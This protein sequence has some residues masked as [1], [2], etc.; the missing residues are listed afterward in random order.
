MDLMLVVFFT[1][2][3]VV[4]FGAIIKPIKKMFLTEPLAA[5]VIGVVLG[6]EVLDIIHTSTVHKDKILEIAAEF[7][8]AM[9][10]MATAFRMPPRFFRKN[11]S[12]LSSIV[13]LGMIL[14]WLATA[15]ILY[16]LLDLSFAECLLIGAIVTPTD[17]VVATTIVTGEMAEKFL[18]SSVRDTISF[19][20]GVNDGL[21]YPIVF[22]SIFLV[23][24][25]DFPLGEW[26]FRTFL[27]QTVCSAVLGYGIGYLAGLMM[28]RAD[29]AGF[30][31]KKAVLPFSLALGFLLLSGLDSLKMNGIIGVFTG[32][33]AFAERLSK[34]EDIMEERVQES[35]ERIFIIPIF[36]L[37]G[38]FLPWKEWH[39]LGWTAVWIVLLVI[40]FRRIPA[41]LAL[42]PLMKKF[43]KKLPDV[44][45]MGWFGPI[46]V[47]ALY[48]A[49]VAKEKASF[50][51]AWIIP[52]LIIF[53]S[54]IIHGI[55]SVPLERWYNQVR[56]SKKK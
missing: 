34:N 27:Y 15:G 47:A 46:G 5:M 36:F 48:Y 56:K 3:I 38:L 22:L 43:R 37:F 25:A 54:T 24:S 42:M 40:F 53:G 18:P 19:E 30:M 23:T 4:A 55:T 7:T 51:E 6:P 31:N 26:V 16:A 39:S 13:V 1:S 14:M 50:Q 9:A 32:G 45:I 29:H 17:P 52:S 2:L 49:I 20:A 44:L 21:A 33:L 28:N 10:L 11:A 41:F 8:I 35:M 12:T